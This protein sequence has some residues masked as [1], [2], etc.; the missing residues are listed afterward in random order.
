VRQGFEI[1]L[2]CKGWFGCFNHLFFLLGSI[3][4]CC[5]PWDGGVEE[6]VV[7][8]AIRGQGSSNAAQQ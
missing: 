2:Y 8:L 1:S 4:I 6:I 7:Y 5:C 3:L